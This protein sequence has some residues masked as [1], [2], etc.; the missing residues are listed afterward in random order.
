MVNTSF[1]VRINR[2]LASLGIATRRGA[3]KLIKEKKVFLNGR[4][5]VLGDMAQK[6]DV[7]KIKNADPKEYIYLAYYKPRG[8]ITHSPQTGEK[9]I[10]DALRGQVLDRVFPI[11]RLDKDSHGLIMLTNDGR[12]TEKLLSPEKEREKEYVVTVDKPITAKFLKRMEAGVN[13][14]GYVTKPARAKKLSGQQFL[15]I[16]TEGKKHQLRRMCAALG[17][18]VRDILRTR[19]MNIKLGSLQSGQF[20]VITGKELK[21]FLVALRAQKIDPP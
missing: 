19:I 16:I 13:I 18:A 21:K 12:I 7:V 9:S 4:V 8:I 1:P 11:G 5:A 20:R 2:H 10:E 6:D 15:I 3:D 17:Y 14:E